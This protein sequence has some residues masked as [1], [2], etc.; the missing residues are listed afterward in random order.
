[1]RLPQ[2]ALTAFRRA[3]LFAGAL[4]LIVGCSDVD[5][6]RG[7][8]ITYEA[9]RVTLQGRVCAEDTRSAR[10]P[11][12]TIFLVDRASALDNMGM[13][14]GTVQTWDPTGARVNLLD[15]FIQSSLSQNPD[16]QFA[17][18]GYGGVSEI[19]APTDGA[20]FTNDI[21]PLMAGLGQL[22]TNAPCVDGICRDPVAGLRTARSLIE[23]DLA[24]VEAGERVLTQ[25]QV[26]FV[27]GGKALP[28]AQAANCCAFDDTACRIA[29]TA[30]SEACENELELE[31]MQGTIDAV[32]DAGALGLRYHVMQFDATTV[33]PG[34]LNDLSARLETTAFSVGGTY[35]RFTTPATLNGRMFN[36]LSDRETLRAKFL[37]V[38]NQNAVPTGQGFAIDSDA[39]GAPDEDEILAGTNPYLWDT[40]GDEIGDLVETLVAFDPLVPDTPVPCREVDPGDDDLDGLSNCDEALLGTEAT[41]VDTDG[42]ALPDPL[43]VF[44][45]VD[46]LTPDSEADSDGDGVSNGEE[47]RIRS[48]ARTGDTERHLPEGYRY[49]VTDEGVVRELFTEQPLLL[50]DAV[51]IQEVGP[52]TTPGRG[53]L[54][55]LDG[56]LSW[57]DP[58]ETQPGPGIDL[59]VPENIPEDG[60]LVLSADSRMEGTP[61][62]EGAYALVEV[63]TRFLPPRDAVEPIR[64]GYRDRQCVNYTVRNVQLMDTAGTDDGTGVLEDVGVNRILLF[65]AEKASGASVRAPGPVR[66]A[67]IPVYFRPPAFR[68]PNSPAIQILDDEFVR[69]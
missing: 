16:A 35:Q 28:F 48:N 53:E 45:F 7:D 39:D 5:L 6:Y 60:L 64:V 68:I 40:D 42:D 66:I 14:L 50:E 51:F 65:F 38:S 32:N 10:L 15:R 33:A 69:R 61:D 29:G 46:Y 30:P 25:Y 58:G 31:V 52:G 21:S 62:G 27:M 55:Y 3:P 44:G 57:R 12:K 13:P 9:D 22:R 47:I 37:I 49:E 18:I 4:L 43:E 54:V 59:S 63:D 1:M 20:N 8:G 24:T 34:D 26:V 36:V 56:I 19:L 41:L 67:E 11:I 17:I 2:S 23:G